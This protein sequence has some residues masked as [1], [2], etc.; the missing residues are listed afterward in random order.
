MGRPKKEQVNEDVIKV[1]RVCGKRSSQDEIDIFRSNDELYALYCNKEPF[2]I[3][4]D[5]LYLKRIWGIVKVDEIVE[6]SELGV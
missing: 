6:N 1:V 4:N 2:M 3:P 5:E